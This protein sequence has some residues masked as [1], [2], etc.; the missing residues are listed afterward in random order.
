MDV[1]T[2]GK[3]VLGVEV[4]R[5]IPPQD[6]DAGASNRAIDGAGTDLKALRLQRGGEP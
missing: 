6:V 3:H 2:G 5:R 1:A 4:R